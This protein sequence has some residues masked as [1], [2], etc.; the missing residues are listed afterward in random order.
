MWKLVSSS[1]SKSWASCKCQG[2]KSFCFI[3][4]LLGFK[5]D[6]Y[7]FVGYTVRNLQLVSWDSQ[8]VKPD[9]YGSERSIGTFIIYRVNFAC[10]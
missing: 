3:G 7:G 9:V 1:F 4:D 6:L 10:L 5:N 8:G 2:K